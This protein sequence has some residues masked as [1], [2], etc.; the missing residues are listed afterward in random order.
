[1]QD[2]LEVLLESFD[3]SIEVARHV[4]Q[5]VLTKHL[6]AMGEPAVCD[7]CDAVVDLLDRGVDLARH[8]PEDRE[9]Q[10]QDHHQPD[11]E[12]D[13]HLPAFGCDLV[14]VDPAANDPAPGSEQLHIGDLGHR[15]AGLRLQEVVGYEAFPRLPGDLRDFNHVGLAGGILQ[16][17]DGLPFELRPRGMHEHSGLEVVDKEVV[18]ALKAEAPEGALCQGLALGPVRLSRRLHGRE[19]FDDAVGD[20]HHRLIL[21]LPA[22]KELRLEGGQHVEGFLEGE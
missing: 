21:S 4:R 13:G 6:E 2:S 19:V 17:R 15:L 5:F 16:V 14:Q 8:D 10:C 12:R 18:S 3:Q 7:G 1:M 22:L 20:L 11:A 9:R